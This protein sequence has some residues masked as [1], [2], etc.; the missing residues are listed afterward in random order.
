MMIAAAASP[1][2]IK[3]PVQQDIMPE[4]MNM[5]SLEINHHI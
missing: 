3:N 4:Y 2:G 5:A 1:L